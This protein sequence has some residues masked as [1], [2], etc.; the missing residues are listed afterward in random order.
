MSKRILI[1]GLLVVV[2]CGGLVAYN[3]LPGLFGGGKSFFGRGGRPPV[4]VEAVTVKSITWQPSVEAVGT[5]RASE[6]ADLAVSA[7]GIVRTIAFAANDRA[8]AGQLLVQIDD[9]Q[10]RADMAAAQANINLYQRQLDRSASLKARGFET[11]ANIDNLRAQLEVARSTYSHAQATAQLK[12]IKAPFDGLLGIPRVNIG[13]Y[14]SA[15]TPI[16]T[17]QNLSLMKVDFTVPEQ[18]AARLAAGQVARFGVAPEDLPFKGRIIGID[19]KVD[20]ETR[21]VAVQGE[22]ENPDGRVLPGQFLRVRVELAAEPN[23]LALPQTAVV[24]S[25]YG[26]YVY[27]VVPAKGPDGK[28]AMTAK[29]V[30]VHTGRHDLDTVEILDGLKE[31]DLVVSAGQNKLQNNAR[32]AVEGPA[33]VEAPPQQPN[34]GRAE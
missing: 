9:S 13:Q 2:L 34:A 19:P 6:G 24:T 28:E 17:L 5:A 23:V 20:P 8:T 14:V 31:G 7:A 4:T 11:Q 32:V 27:A 33:Q 30:F 3:L 29:Q 22:L 10:E 16:V 12:A 26:D 1:I 18:S 15:G 21:L 25:L